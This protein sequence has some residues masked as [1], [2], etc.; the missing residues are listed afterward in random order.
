MESP[1]VSEYSRVGTF[2][3]SDVRQQPMMQQY[4]MSQN[5]VHGSPGSNYQQTTV[6]QTSPGYV[7]AGA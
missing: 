6:T 1:A 5:Q 4:K 3:P 7:N 2:I